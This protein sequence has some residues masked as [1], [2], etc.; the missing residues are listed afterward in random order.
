ME[1]FGPVSQQHQR[2]PPGRG[3][4]YIADDAGQPRAE[5]VRVAQ[6][7]QAR[8]R[9]Q[10][11][12]LHDVI[13]L[14]RIRAQPRRQSPR[15]RNVPLNQQRERASVTGAGPPDQ[16][17]VADVHTTKCQ[18]GVPRLP[19]SARHATVRTRPPALP[20]IGRR[21]A[22]TASYPAAGN[23]GHP[24]GAVRTEQR[25]LR[26]AIAANDAT[27]RRPESAGSVFEIGGGAQRRVSRC[28]RDV[29]SQVSALQ[30]RIQQG[31]ARSCSSAGRWQAGWRVSEETGARV[32]PGPGRGATISRHRRVCR[33]WPCS[34]PAR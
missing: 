30:R 7:A 29:T 10:E 3:A 9:L 14:V 26:A 13:H 31:C 34:S 24:G 16:L 33:S 15:R 1:I 11:R 23:L 18:P 20:E 32:R 28:R 21:P 5:P 27:P 6:P 8:E 19:A 12:L 22:R 25:G 17:T 2:D 4:G